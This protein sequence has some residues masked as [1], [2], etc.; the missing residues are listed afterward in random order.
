MVE[1][2][3]AKFWSAGIIPFIISRLTWGVSPNKAYEYIAMGLRIISAPMG[4]VYTMPSSYIYYNQKE[5]S[6]L[7]KKSV[8]K[9]ISHEE[10]LKINEYI[11]NNSWNNRFNKIL[12]ILS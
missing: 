9:E 5:M 3:Y 8:N 2:Q 10:L 4:Q 12:K 7:I 11:L 1:C 6:L